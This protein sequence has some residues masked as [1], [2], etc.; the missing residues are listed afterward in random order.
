MKQCSAL[1]ATCLLLGA[2][3]WS[4]PRRTSAGS[5]SRELPSGNLSVKG[6][7]LS[8]ADVVNQVAPAVVTIRSSRRVRAPQQFP[9]FDDPFFQQFFGGRVP[10]ARGNSTTVEHA[11]G[12][13]VIVQPD[14]H[15]LTNEHVIDGAEDIKV[16]L[17][18]RKTYSAKVVGSD[19]PSDL[20]VLTDCLCW[21]SAI[22]M[23][24]A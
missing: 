7:L 21:S 6:P 9:F 11:L 10:Q 4:A 14:G 2:C 23:R 15:I 22:P 18:N 17:A 20:A 19:A 13:G 1:V 12:S 16:D 3:Q 24:S 5:A 8:Y